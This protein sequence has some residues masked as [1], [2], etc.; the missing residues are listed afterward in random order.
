MHCRSSLFVAGCVLSVA[1]ATSS[2]QEAIIIDHTCCDISQVPDSWVEAAKTQFLMSYGHTSHGS[3]IVTGMNGIKN[4]PG[5][6]YWWDHDGTQGGLSLWD[7]TPSGDLGNP[8]YYTWEVR[9]RAMLDQPDNDRNCV[10]WSWCGQADTSEANMQIYLDL[11]SGLIADYPDVTF[12]Y[13]TGHLTGT[14]EGGNL[15]ARN[16]QI[17]D[18]VIATGGILFDFADIESYDPDG[19]YFLDRGAD[20]GCNYDGGNWAIEWCD[21]HPGDP[22]CASCSCAH[23]QP[24]NCNLKGRAFWWMMARVAG[25][26]GPTT[27]C[28][29]DL[30]GDG[31]TDQSDMGIL[32]AAYGLTA[33]GDLD[34]DGDTDQED[35]GILLNDYDCTP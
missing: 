3:Q 23:S 15:H 27:D 6:L 19:E 25:W 12:I 17:R 9:T 29:G 14:G 18:H 33:A 10:L 30:D 11:M 2:A 13:M 7:Y 5:S 20:D 32:L 24:L 35:L 31:D 16:N 26:V 22:L 8:D 1:A 4:P 34:G 28:V 21:A